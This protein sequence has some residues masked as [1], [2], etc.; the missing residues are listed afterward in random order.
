[1]VEGVADR[2]LGSRKA[3]TLVKLLVL[4][5]G[6][7]VRVDSIAEVLWG[8]ALPAQPAEQVGVLVSRLRRVLGASRLP[9]TDAGYAL[10]A[11]WLDV[12]EVATLG[13]WPRPLSPR[14]APAPATRPGRHPRGRHP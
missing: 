7:P 3:R 10:R 8:E 4:A 6:A 13:G 11:D 12:D 14:A 9:R 5:R 1:M 2:D